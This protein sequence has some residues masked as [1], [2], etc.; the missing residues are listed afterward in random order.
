MIKEKI[1]KIIDK[2]FDCAHCKQLPEGVEA[3]VSTVENLAFGHYSTNVAM[4]LAKD[5]G[6]NPQEVGLELAAKIREAAPKNLFEKV[7][8]AGPGFINFFLSAKTLQAELSEIYKNRKDYGNINVGKGKKVIVE[9]SQPNI[10]K[11][12]HV[13]HLRSTI[14]GDS[15]ANIFEACGYKVVRWNYLGDWGTQFGKLIYAYKQWGNK[16]AVKKNPIEEL[17]RLYVYFHDQVK[18]DATLGDR[19]REEFK[20]LE[21]GDRENRALWKWFREES[22]KEFKKIY[23]T[24]GINF[25]V[26]IGE[27]AYEKQMAPI[28]SEL[29]KKGLAKES[30]GALVV[31]L[32]EENLPVALVAKSD[33]ASLYLTRDLASARDRNKKYK[34]QQIIYVVANEQTLH[35]E[36]MFAVAKKIGVGS[37]DLKHAK[38]G[39]VLGEDRKKLSTREGRAIQLEELISKILV[40]AEAAID[41]KSSGLSAAKKRKIAHAV[42]IGALKYNDLKE[43]RN[44]DIV[45]DWERMLDFSGNSAPYLQYTRARLNRIIKK[46][47]KVYEVDFKVL[48]GEAEFGLIKKLLDF[49]EE[50]KKSAETL[51]TNNLAT[52][53]FSLAV[54]A[55]KFYETTPILKEESKAKRAAYL[56]LISCVSEVIKRGL[57][58]LGIESPEEI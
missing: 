42:G 13:G 15:L 29:K 58:L 44:S 18:T 28:I 47:G 51:Y 14:I 39:L 38:F 33:G 36:Q 2:Q 49:P 20:K 22:L 57:N 55:N 30:E 48:N 37:A 56:A 26:W 11:K 46:A 10:A 27:S 12:M 31:D 7:E 21:D 3:E 1:K 9:Y 5:L 24:L 45:F 52:Y 6:R 35:F 23:K 40:L 50:I 34:P 8:V 4:R 32:T 43:N 17:L 19:G 53:I 54:L 41:K 16:A 25:D